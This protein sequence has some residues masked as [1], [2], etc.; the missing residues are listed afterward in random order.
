MN[1]AASMKILRL[2]V[3]MMMMMMRRE[4]EREG[5][6]KGLICSRHSSSSSRPSSS[7]CYSFLWLL[8]LL[9]Q[10]P[11]RHLQFFIFSRRVQK[12]EWIFR[13][14]APVPSAP[15]TQ[16]QCTLAKYNKRVKSENNNN[17]TKTKRCS[18]WSTMFFSTP[19]DD[20]ADDVMI[21]RYAVEY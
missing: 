5:E 4:N 19:S 16:I 12:A 13:S 20:D 11:G 3:L 21:P 1:K 6:K 15:T 18:S 7:G 9:L 17:K 2:Q 8:L 14:F 10:P